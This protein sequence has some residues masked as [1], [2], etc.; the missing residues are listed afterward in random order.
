[1]YCHNCGSAQADQAVFCAN[2]GTR[3]QSTPEVIPTVQAQPSRRATE[4]LATTKKLL[5]WERNLW[6]ICSILYFVAGAIFTLVFLVLGK[7][8]GV[9]AITSSIMFV[10]A[11]L[12]GGLFIGLGLVDLVTALKITPH[13]NNMEKNFAPTANRLESIGRIVF[14]A[15]FN[16]Y[17]LIFYIINFVRMKSNKQLV[18]EII[19]MQ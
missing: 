12:Y 3:L 18:D 5:R 17:A 2:C 9:D 15:I 10:Y 6:K 14:A 8:E 16:N 4:F 1:M 19:S 13:L 7:H 11:F